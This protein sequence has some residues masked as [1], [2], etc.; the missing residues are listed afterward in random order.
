MDVAVNLAAVEGRRLVRN[1]LMWL[2]MI[3]AVLW[4][5]L[6]D[7]ADD[8]HFVLTG[9]GLIFTCFA[10][11]VLVAM[12][13]RRSRFNHTGPLLDVLPSGSSTRT[14]GLGLAGVAPACAA[15][16][17]TTV[18]WIV[19]WPSTSLGTSTQTVNSGVD[20]PRP[21]FAQF[22]Q[23]PLA[24]GV[25]GALGLVLARWFP[26][27]LIGA[28]LAVPMLIQFLWFGGWHAEGSHAYVWLVPLATGWV[29]DGWTGAC[30]NTDANCD[31][32][33][34]GFDQTTPWL[35]LGYLVALAA[36]LI[37]IAVL[38]RH[39][40]RRTWMI[41]CAALASVAVFVVAQWIVYERFEP[42]I[43]R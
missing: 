39:R 29:T 27:W 8:T 23:G 10:V 30:D 16:V 11:T 19:V 22:L 34:S 31:L 24:I 43:A 1:P 42:V 35:H 14:V 26:G 5:A 7:N 25:F 17:A 15:L 37:A 40:D 41:F 33:L 13:A 36:T 18:V 32:A 28:A 20:V 9:Y 3:P 21:N 4:A 6:V 38:R 2:S 12:A